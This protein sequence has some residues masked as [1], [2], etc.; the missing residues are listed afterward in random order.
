MEEEVEGIRSSSWRKI[1]DAEIEKDYRGE[2]PILAV[3]QFSNEDEPN[4]HRI[5]QP[6]RRRAP[7]GL[8]E[9]VLADENIDHNGGK[10]ESNYDISSTASSASAS[11]KITGTS[12]LTPSD[13]LKDVLKARAELDAFL[14]GNT[15]LDERAI[16]KGASSSSKYLAA[17]TSSTNRRKISINAD[18]G[19]VSH[20]PANALGGPFAAPSGFF[21]CADAAGKSILPKI[22][23]SLLRS[24]SF[25]D[26]ISFL[27]G[28][29]FPFLKSNDE[30]EGDIFSQLNDNEE[31]REL[32]AIDKG[33]INP[34]TNNVIT[35]EGQKKTPIHTKI[36]RTGRSVAFPLL[37][38]QEFFSESVKSGSRDFLSQLADSITNKTLSTDGERQSATS[39]GSSML[40]ISTASPDGSWKSDT[41]KKVTQIVYQHSSKRL[42]DGQNDPLSAPL[43]G[44]EQ[45]L[46]FP[47]I[48]EVEISSVNETYIL[49]KGDSVLY[50][51]EFLKL[52]KALAEAIMDDDASISPPAAQTAAARILAIS[53]RMRSTRI[54]YEAAVRLSGNPNFSLIIQ[55]T[56]Y[57]PPVSISFKT[58]YH[59]STYGP[60][61]TINV[62]I[63]FQLRSIENSHAD[64]SVDQLIGR[65][66]AM[67]IQ[68]I[69]FESTQTQTATTSSQ[70]LHLHVA[71]GRVDLLFFMGNNIESARDM[72]SALEPSILRVMLAAPLPEHAIIAMNAAVEQIARRA[73]DRSLASL[74]TKRRRRRGSA[75]NS[76]RIDVNGAIV[77]GGTA[78]TFAVE[79]VL[80]TGEK[81]GIS[82]SIAKADEDLSS[83]LSIVR[84]ISTTPAFLPSTSA[85]MGVT[86]L[87]FV[88]SIPRDSLA[89]DE[90]E[91]EGIVS[92]LDLAC[93][94]SLSRSAWRNE[95]YKKKTSKSRADEGKESSSSSTEYS[96]VASSI[97]M[98]STAYTQV[99][100]WGRGE[101]GLLGI[102]DNETDYC[103]P[104]PIPFASEVGTWRVKA[105]ACGSFH[106]C[107]ITDAGLLYTWG[108]GGDGQLG[109]GDSLSCSSPRLVD[110][111]GFQHPLRVISIAAGSDAAG[112]H[113]VAVATGRL[114]DEEIDPKST[115][116]DDTDFIDIGQSD[117]EPLGD[118]GKKGGSTVATLGRVFA[119]GFGTA[120]GAPSINNVLQPQLVRAS[121]SDIYANRHG[122]VMTVAAGGGF[123]LALT[124][125][126]AV[127]SWGKYANG[128]LGL[129]IPP[130]SR[131]RGYAGAKQYVRY[132]L[133]P[134]RITS[135]WIARDEDVDK[136]PSDEE[137]KDE[138]VDGISSTARETPRPLPLISAVANAYGKPTRPIRSIA[139]GEAHALAIDAYGLIWSWGRGQLGQLGLGVVADVLAPKM[140]RVRRRGGI[141]TD[142]GGSSSA[143]VAGAPAEDSL[144]T[145]GS[146]DEG[147]AESVISS[148]SDLGGN[149]SS[150]LGSANLGP[151]LPVRFLSVA[152]GVSHS[153]AVALDGSLYSWGG[154]GFPA[155][156]HGDQH[157]RTTM[158]DTPMSV[159]ARMQQRQKR[160]LLKLQRD[161]LSTFQR[162]QAE[163]AETEAK[164]LK[165]DLQRKKR[166]LKQNSL[167]R[168]FPIR[169]LELF[170]VHAEARAKAEDAAKKAGEDFNE[171]DEEDDDDNDFDNDD[172]DDDD[173]DS[174]DN[175]D[176]KGD[177]IS[178]RA[179]RRANKFKTAIPAHLRLGWKYPWLSPR[180]VRVFDGSVTSMRVSKA[181]GGSTFSWA[182]TDSGQLFLWGENSNGVLGS[183]ST[184]P[185]YYEILPRLVGVT[186]QR[187]GFADATLASGSGGPASGAHRM[188]LAGEN[189]TCVGS[190][191]GHV[192]VATAAS[193]LGANLRAAL[194]LGPVALIPEYLSSR[195]KDYLKRH[196]M[197][198]DDDAL[199]ENA[200]I[201]SSSKSY[202]VS[203]RVYVRGFDTAL[204]VDGR[205]IKAH[206]AILAA[207]S[208]VFAARLESESRPGK[209]SSKLFISDMAFT[210]AALLVE[211]IYTDD[212]TVPLTPKGSALSELAEAALK[213][214]L[215]RLRS[216][217]QVM[218]DAPVTYWMRQLNVKD[219]DFSSI[220]SDEEIGDKLL[221]LDP[222][223][224]STVT[225]YQL[226][227]PPLARERQMQS[228]FELA[229]H[230]GANLLPMHLLRNCLLDPKWAD[231]YLVADGWRFPVHASIVCASCEYFRVLL[232]ESME[233]DDV[234]DNNRFGDAITEINS[235]V[236]G[237]LLSAAE[238][239]EPVEVEVP[240]SAMTL[241]RLIFFMYTGW[242]AP[243]PISA[244]EANTNGFIPGIP[245]VCERT[246]SDDSD[247]FT[248][249][250]SP[251][252]SSDDY[253]NQTPPPLQQ[254]PSVKST[255]TPSSQMLLDLVAADRYGIDHLKLLVE[256]AMDVSPL[257]VAQVLELSS[258]VPVPRI[259]ECAV[260]SALSNMT[261]VTTSRG[262]KNMQFRSPRLVG[263]LLDRALSRNVDYFGVLSDS[264]ATS[265]VLARLAPKKRVDPL[266]KLFKKTVFPWKPLILLAVLFFAFITFAEYNTSMSALVPVVN[267]LVLLAVGI[268]I[269]QGWISI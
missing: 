210:T 82:D 168:L 124:R 22:E 26:Y 255:W 108:N 145:A 265:T 19:I 247:V 221:T 58:G 56:A 126:G 11:F 91:E 96:D 98:T 224:P 68:D 30:T 186:S 183:G 139:C 158:Y 114:A 137:D 251:L 144:S 70:D 1:Y 125:S 264:T 24:N 190:G 212:L 222:E 75:D 239:G 258:L 28:V 187:G 130:L 142:V 165:R 194:A 119:W 116:V 111:F 242:L 257:Q 167:T 72:L 8:I 38:R 204:F 259:R 147:N 112:S 185:N 233:S 42:T 4:A 21:P 127:Y 39:A 94:H 209:K 6:R 76:Q 78:G 171:D 217:C 110:F 205:T 16:L 138:N 2:L 52:S 235:S 66:F 177:V 254:R 172:D 49:N 201:L 151:L 90:M 15:M 169:L 232:R 249:A 252:P 92:A 57:I 243:L 203:S 231:M 63:V 37:H 219:S 200:S 192:V 29:V 100:A 227:T 88:T 230:K 163:A 180:R 215:P 93:G 175:E 153:L 234:S 189:V 109:H 115:D 32:D 123:T 229:D 13:A 44:S 188:R 246:L 134:T 228:A 244:V 105:I 241:S 83:S 238:E 173:G 27:G 220:K 65:I 146:I 184:D 157:L 262:Y 67:V 191:H 73:K 148:L 253:T 25:S 156:G 86:S 181:G 218:I 84:S 31:E 129:G 267:V 136:P 135:G 117:S 9:A 64:K 55:D 74:L 207:R 162:F 87:N 122:G 60:G 214:N 213:Y 197:G 54:A 263:E 48:D 141:S 99:Y 7:I 240:D 45:I 159:I 174:D 36:I 106:T 269:Y 226:M 149:G 150:S 51:P 133:T 41:K 40:E 261:D 61:A 131:S 199:G 17:T 268:G 20:Q 101:S 95:L 18:T 132:S 104:I 79:S 166:R 3:G 182:V 46:S 154:A 155:L 128:R 53:S 260:I 164:K 208:S 34:S 50:S 85:D 107:A 14:S 236:S 245:I 250:G 179:K 178:H 120:V 47:S 152:C 102:G 176:T 69:A 97:P 223:D 12:I 225:P 237:S 43:I 216:I 62:P 23:H 170:G 77:V 113:T 206:R 89:H 248:R 140:V 202:S 256:S 35:T 71:S 211:F 33:V 80:E 10:S 266:T 5:M 118:V 193:L 103:T 143:S 121:A 161:H 81:V 195:R 196:T 59:G 160:E 198:Q